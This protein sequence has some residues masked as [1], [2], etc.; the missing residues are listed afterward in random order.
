MGF[1]QRRRSG[2]T[3]TVS[4]ETCY[5]EAVDLANLSDDDLM[6]CIA[7][8]NERG[9]AV[10]G[11]PR[12]TLRDIQHDL[13]CRRHSIG[14]T[15]AVRDGGGSTTTSTQFWTRKW[16]FGD[17]DRRRHAKGPQVLDPGRHQ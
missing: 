3:I 9:L 5:D 14:I 17:H 10:N 12:V 15:V 6:Q 2:R 8:A 13:L 16:S 4:G 11:V 7:E 1:A